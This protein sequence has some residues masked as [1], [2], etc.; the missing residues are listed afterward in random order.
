MQSLKTITNSYSNSNNI[1]INNSNSYSK[2]YTTEQILDLLNN[3]NDVI[4]SDG[5]GGFYVNQFRRL[6]YDRFIELVNKA[7]AGSDTPAKLFCWM[8]KNDKVV[9]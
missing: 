2:I 7:R 5:Y 8:L 6:G 1:N 9:R 4:P 3:L